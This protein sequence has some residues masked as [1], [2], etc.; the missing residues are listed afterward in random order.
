MGI[1]EIVFLLLVTGAFLT[2]VYW[3]SSQQFKLTWRNFV[4]PQESSTHIDP[5]MKT[6][7][8]WTTWFGTDSWHISPLGYSWDG[9]KHSDLRDLGCDQDSYRCTITSDRSYLEDESL[10]DAVLFH[11][12]DINPLDLPD[13]QQ[14]KPG[15]VYMFNTLESPRHSITFAPHSLNYDPSINNNFFNVTMTYSA[16]SAVHIPYGRI[17][18]VRPHP[19]GE[20]LEQ[21]ITQYGEQN[22]GQV[23]PRNFSAT[24]VVSN[25]ASVSGREQVLGEMSALM[26]VK[27]FGRCGEP[28]PERW[29]PEEYLAP[30]AKTFQFYLAFENSLCDDYVSER[31]FHSLYADMIPVVMNAANMSTIA[32][33]NS[34][35]DLKE[36]ETLK[37]LVNYMLRV[38][39]DPAL[40][41]S[42][43]W[44][45]HHYEIQAL[46]GR[47][48]IKVFCEACRY[49]HAGKG[50]AIVEDLQAE[51]VEA[52]QCV[53][54]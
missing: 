47:N 6:I 28:L 29:L 24:I 49:L 16:K 7:L 22:K 27:I 41:A 10:Y 39:S 1:H 31:F 18:Q 2:L 13:Q 4:E 20:E 12:V 26:P 9:H 44:W 53:A 52:G 43:F 5:D 32:P 37:D 36:F 25:C 48:F 23:V 30:L 40:Y 46:S 19:S 54:V 3:S 45:K 14:R 17:V 50:P 11:Q 34:Y 21:F 15:Q 51:W 8:L 35:I 38:S 33:K 42:Y